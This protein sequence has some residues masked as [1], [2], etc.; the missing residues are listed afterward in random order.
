MRPYNLYRVSSLC[1]DGIGARTTGAPE[2]VRFFFFRDEAMTTLR[3]AEPHDAGA[4]AHLRAAS[5]IE[6]GY[7]TAAD[8]D[9]FVRRAAVD[10]AR[11]FDDARLVAHVLCDAQT[12]VGSACAIFFDRLPF[13]D[14]ALHA[15]ISGVYVAPTYRGAGHAT[16]LVD[17]V[18]AAVRRSGARRTF[19]RPT[20]GSKALYERLGF[21]DDEGGL[22]RL[23]SAAKGR[24][25]HD[26]A[27]NV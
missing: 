12:V 10:F 21:V 6:L 2:T 11:L 26:Y 3:P 20:A 18:V 13:P 24:S 27:N 15:E 25:L 8:E 19:L 9:A 17:L 16:R 22:M 5:M 14:G 1:G 4:L 7:L 23:A